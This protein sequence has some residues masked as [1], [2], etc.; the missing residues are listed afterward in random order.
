VRSTVLEERAVPHIIRAVWVL[1]TG[2]NYWPT[3]AEIRRRR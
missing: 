3:L 1:L 2:C